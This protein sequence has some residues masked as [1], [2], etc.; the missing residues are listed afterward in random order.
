[1][2]MHHKRLAALKALQTLMAIVAEAPDSLFNPPGYPQ[3]TYVPRLETDP[4][5]K[6]MFGEGIP[7]LLKR[8]QRDANLRLREVLGRTPDIWPKM[9]KA[10]GKTIKIRRWTTPAVAA[11]RPAKKRARRAASK[12]KK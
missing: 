10:R 5:E 2:S 11:P 4:D 3:L 8:Q 6:N 1:M 7:A 12:N 9:P